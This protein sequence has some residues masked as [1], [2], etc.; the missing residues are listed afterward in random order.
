[1]PLS[2]VGTGDGAKPRTAAPFESYSHGHT[3]NFMSNA[4]SR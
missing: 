2:L 3:F 4:K 1:M